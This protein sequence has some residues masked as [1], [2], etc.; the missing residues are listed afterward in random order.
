MNIIYKFMVD[1]PLPCLIAGWSFQHFFRIRNPI[2]PPGEYVASQS[3]MMVAW[4]I[5]QGKHTLGQRILQRVMNFYYPQD[6]CM[7]YMLTFTINIPQM[8]AYMYTIHGCYIQYHKSMAYLCCDYC[9][10]Q[11]TLRR[12]QLA[13]LA[14]SSSNCWVYGR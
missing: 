12:Y 5:Q 2:Q 4:C 6:P 11:R 3:T 13:K 10:T 14:Y 7:L 9:P 1:F 8:L